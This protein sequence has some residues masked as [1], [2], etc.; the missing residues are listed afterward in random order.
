MTCTCSA[1]QSLSRGMTLLLAAA[2]ALAVATVYLAQPLLESMAAS[3]GI[4]PAHAGLVVG[5]TQAGYALGLL[6]IVPLGDLLD[7]RRLIIAQLL[8]AAGALLAVALA[9]RWA[10]LLGAVALVGLLAVVVQVLVAHAATLASPTQQGQALGTVTSGVVLGILLAR[11]VSGLVADRLGWRGVYFGAAGLTLLMAALLAWRLPAA[12]AQG[13]RPGYWAI[14]CSVLGLYR[15]DRLLRQRGLLA[16]LVFAAFSVLWSAMVLP[17]SAA[18]LAL[19]HTQVGLFGLAGIAGALAAS[20]A[21]RLADLGQ[22]RRTT[23]LALGLLTLSWLPTAF[24]EQSLLA[25]VIGVVLLDLA[26]QAVHV[27]SQS[28]LLAGRSEIASRLIGAYMC[29][30]SL[31]SGLGAVAATWVYGQWGW[32]A[33]CGL[34]AGVSAVA[35]C[36]WW[37]QQPCAG[38]SQAGACG[39]AV[40]QNL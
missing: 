40:N 35:G 14:L 8:V 5:M 3:F 6:L 37:F 11:L 18:P 13:V 33:V 9:T 29:C 17:L 26:V 21:G 23:G 28:L 15:H 16:L 39:K 12:R 10:M 25:L 19:D 30:Y 36:C 20:R 27:T 38:A 34:G 22:G 32:W 31:G 4:N 7:R 2:C 24:L 1:P